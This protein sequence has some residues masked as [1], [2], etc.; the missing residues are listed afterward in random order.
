MLSTSCWKRSRRVPKKRSLL[1][2]VN[3]Q[4]FK[5]PPDLASSVKT[6]IDDW[7]A[8]GK[9]RRLWQRDASLWTNTDEANWL[10]WLGIVPDQAARIQ[11]FR[12]FAEDVKRAGFT[13]V[14]LLGMGGSSLVL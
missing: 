9:V 2:K 3:K 1:T 14:L 4:N 7:R 11:D 10:G 8:N 5:L 6:H 13:H 12:N